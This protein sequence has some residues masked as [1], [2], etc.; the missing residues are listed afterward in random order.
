MNIDSKDI[1]KVILPR[2]LTLITCDDGMGGIDAIPSDTIIP[3]SSDPSILII[4][5]NPKYKIF[6][7]MLNQKDF[8]INILPKN[9]SEKILECVKTYPRGIDKL[10]QV[11]LN[12][13]D[14]S[15]MK[16]KGV[17]EA[18]VLIGCELSD[19]MQVGQN[20]VIFGKVVLVEAD[21]KIVVNG[22]IDIKK[23][24]PPLRFSKSDLFYIN[25]N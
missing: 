14:L 24:D 11:G 21:D 25:T 23:L 20:M 6:K 17:K 2:L 19:K 5:M 18:K 13:R 4:V 9:Y 10:E 15:G 12:A 3:V 1:N 16:S 8:I 7:N 22:A